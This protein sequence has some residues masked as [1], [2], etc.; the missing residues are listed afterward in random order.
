M[1]PTRRAA[2]TPAEAALI[3]AL[4]ALAA[5]V[6]L[7]AVSRVRSEAARAACQNNLRRLGAAALGSESAQGVLPAGCLPDGWGPVAQLLP[8]LGRDD[9]ARRIVLRP[10][11]TLPGDLYWH[12]PANRAALAET[13][14][15][16]A[17]PSAPPP[18]QAAVR[19]V[20]MYYGSPE[21]EFPGAGQVHAGTHISISGDLGR[22]L[23][24]T[25]YLGVAGDW[26]GGPGARGA[27]S[28][29]SRTTS[30]MIP[31]GTGCTFLFGEAVGG[32]FGTPGRHAMYS[33]GA[34][35]HSTAFGLAANSA[36]PMAGAKFASA[37]PKVIHFGY[38]D[39]S[40][41]PLRN[42][43]QFTGSAGQPKFT[44]LGGRADG[45]YIDFD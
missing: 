15:E 42:P 1:R 20:G 38:C 40:V 27:M 35:A 6:A 12:D 4:V 39:G 36:E 41:R 29:Q 3:L 37:H 5:A 24:A 25:H 13:I 11:T 34:N 7:P 22:S 17:C 31:D 28:Y 33:W 16:L 32:D 45:V 19:F 23:A 18:N 21:V 14:P 26:R 44:A 30:E 43:A 2:V 10:Y 8:E 9:L